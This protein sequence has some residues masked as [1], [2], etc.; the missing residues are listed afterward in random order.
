MPRKTINFGT[1]SIPIIFGR[2]FFPTL[3]GML[4]VATL[5]VAE[6][7]FVGRG[8]GS[9]G[10]AAINI[11]SPLFMITTGIAL[12]F[13]IGSSIV[14]S[15]H[16]SH[17]NIKAARI[18]L[19]QAVI[20]ASL[21]MLL[22][23]ALV[24]GFR[25]Q[26]A[27]M[28]GSSDKL[29]PMVLVYIE[30]L[31][32]FLI[33]NMIMSMGLFI[34]RLDGS[35]VYAMLCNVIP[36]ILN[37]VLCW[38]FVI[39]FDWGIKGAAMATS[40]GVTFGGAMVIIYS[41]FFS[42][43]LQLHK[44]KFNRS[45]LWKSFRDVVYMAKLGSSAFMGEMA[46]TAM[47]LIGNYVFI[48]ALGEDGV[49]AFSV[50]CYCFPVIYMLGNAVAQSAQPI[51][52]YNYGAGDMARVKKTVGISIGTALFCG[53]GAMAGSILFCKP[54]VA[55]FLD[56]TGNAYQIATQGIP[57]FSI[58]YL[59]FAFNMAAVG[60]Y[61]SIEKAKLANIYTLFRGFIFMIICFL[62]LPQLFHVTG[63]WLAVP[64]SEMLTAFLIVGWYLKKK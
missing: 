39:K 17:D 47:V 41:V 6:G 1:M 34:I 48:Y 59:F 36:A 28:F 26:V 18:N 21:I 23:S 44:L 10:L 24:L 9:D 27:Y 63:I 40:I 62:T 31:T 2:L 20:V 33:F 15:I 19:T 11:A 55:L 50:A 8:V 16:L 29:L 53:F 32:P 42:S 54:L 60:Y 3:L 14:A 51:I 13:G 56:P 61:Q 5:I 58:G 45:F 64:F 30:W 46:I 35:P 38:L 25:E 43:K 4:S 12:M 49:A 57:Y 22:I 52:S 37:L 7:I